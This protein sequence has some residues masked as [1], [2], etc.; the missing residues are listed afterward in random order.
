MKK[1]SWDSILLPI[2]NFATK[3]ETRTSA[4]AEVSFERKFSKKQ[5]NIAKA[6]HSISSTAN[7]TA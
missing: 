4:C 2:P 6:H 7:N 1:T 3:P 5:K